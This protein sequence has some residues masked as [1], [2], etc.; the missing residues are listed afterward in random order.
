MTVDDIILKVR[1]RLAD[2]DDEAYTDNMLIEFIN[3]FAKDFSLTGCNQTV[4][5]ITSGAITAS[6]W[7]LSGLT[8]KYLNVYAVT[9]A[10]VHLA[11]AP[12]HEA[13]KWSPS[14]G[15][16]TGWSVW[17]D[18]LYFDYTFTALDVDIYY[19]Y[20]PDD[21]TAVGNTFPLAEK[22]APAAVAYCEYRCRMADR[23][24]GLAANSA[25]EYDTYKKSAAAL[26]QAL[27]MGG[28]Y[29]K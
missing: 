16:P 9:N 3:D 18:V 14:A 4:H 21:I 15:T 23:D 26:Y 1:Y 10:S 25:A 24:A 11:F 19:T 6:G 12:L 13:R 20:I 5:N 17:G 29:S 7:A 27:L 22:W 8:Y 2:V 28:G